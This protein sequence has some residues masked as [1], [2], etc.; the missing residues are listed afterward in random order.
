MMSL[1]LT[2]LQAQKA[3]SSTGGVASG[4]GGSVSYS[5]GQVIFTTNIGINSNSIAEGVQQPYEI[6]V[7]S[8]IDYDIRISLE[9][10][11]YPNPATNII[12]LNIDKNEFI[13]FRYQF[14]DL[15]GNLIKSEI[16]AGDNTQINMQNFIPT[17]YFLKVVQE[18]EVLKT[19]KI[20]KIQ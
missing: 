19:F 7:I 17:T 18:K 15:N 14:Y 20:I 13:N 6:S 5:V 11:V 1:G 3:I 16:I 9:C 10:T 8:G 4:T 12:K 2:G